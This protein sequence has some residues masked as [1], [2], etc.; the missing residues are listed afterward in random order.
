[1][2]GSKKNRRLSPFLFPKGEL[3]QTASPETNSV[4]MV[5]NWNSASIRHIPDKIHPAQIMMD[6]IIFFRYF[7]TGRN[8]MDME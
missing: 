5:H 7:S 8:K 3:Y 4:G 1:M 2:T 6:P